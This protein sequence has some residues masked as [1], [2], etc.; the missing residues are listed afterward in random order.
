MEKVGRKD[1][2]GLGTDQSGHGLDPMIRR[3][4]VRPFSGYSDSG[5]DLAVE[6]GQFPAPYKIGQR[7]VVWKRSELIEWQESRRKVKTTNLLGRK[8]K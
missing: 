4:I 3:K 7:A 1:E 6:K 2:Q 8:G 5:L